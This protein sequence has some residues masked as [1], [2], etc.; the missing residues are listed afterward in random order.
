[1]YLRRS[2]TERV[3][4]A[5]S[6]ADEEFA[7]WM[8]TFDPSKGI[9]PQLC[10][11]SILQLEVPSR[12]SELL[13]CSAKR[14]LRKE[15]FPHVEFPYREAGEQIVDAE[16]RVREK[17]ALPLRIMPQ[18]FQDF[19]H[20][21]VKR[22]LESTSGFVKTLR[23]VQGA[24]GPQ[25]PLAGVAYYWSVD[26][27]TWFDMPSGLTAAMKQNRGIDLSGKAIAQARDVWL[28][29]TE[30]LGHELIREALDIVRPNP[31][32]ALLIGISALE[33][34]L[35]EYIQFRV[36]YADLILEKMPSPPAVTMVQEVI[37]NLHTAMEISS[38]RFPL[39]KKEVDL[40]KKWIGLRN[41]VAHGIEKQLD[42]P[43]LIKFLEFVREL[44]YELDAHRGFD[45]ADSLLKEG[46]EVWQGPA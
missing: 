38:K 42:I 10:C 25:S 32:S 3:T 1:M 22:L 9:Q 43:K 17:W 44:L 23:W 14:V 2:I 16:G 20:L 45:W 33:T 46:L 37:P 24:S 27:T 6:S 40:L 18:N 7:F 26:K 13:D 15:L 8:R 21:T 19:Y 31:R 4:V 28:S 41:Q 5:G 12:I 34:G 29:Q 11:D 36:K 39:A 35:K 30:P